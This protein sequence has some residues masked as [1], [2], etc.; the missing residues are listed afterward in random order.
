MYFVRN[1]IIYIWEY[2]TEKLIEYTEIPNVIVNIHIT[3]PKLDIFSSE[4]K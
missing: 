2:K 4:V 3:Q 1:N